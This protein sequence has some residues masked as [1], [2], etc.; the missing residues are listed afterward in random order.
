MKT[1]LVAAL[2]FTCVSAQ[3]FTASECYAVG[4]WVAATAQARDRG[5][6]EAVTGKIIAR[7]TIGETRESM[8]RL[9][10]AVYVSGIPADQASSGFLKVC[11]GD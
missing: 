10:H 6:P 2:L 5:V 3:A 7:H 1:I 11:L 4:D 8:L 9:T